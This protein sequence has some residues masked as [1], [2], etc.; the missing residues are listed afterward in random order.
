MNLMRSKLFLKLFALICVFLMVM[1]AYLVAYSSAGSP[2]IEKY[3]VAEEDLEDILAQ[4]GRLGG[5]FSAAAAIVFSWLGCKLEKPGRFLAIGVGVGCAAVL[6]IMGAAALSLRKLSQVALRQAAYSMM[7]DMLLRFV[8]ILAM[9]L[10]IVW[11][12]GN[13]IRR[14]LTERK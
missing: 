12:V 8:L 14:H 1:G 6:G 2:F 5:I 7:M 10:A 9:L 11:L 4:C 3:G 13:M